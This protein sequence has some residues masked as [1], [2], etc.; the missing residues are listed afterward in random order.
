M[1]LVRYLD[2][3]HAGNRR[4]IVV[5]MG[6]KG[7]ANDSFGNSLQIRVERWHGMIKLIK[8]SEAAAGRPMQFRTAP[9]WYFSDDDLGN[10]RR[11]MYEI[12]VE[13][14]NRLRFLCLGL[15]TKE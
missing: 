11:Y 3:W 2:Y 15:Y 8:R 4:V 1:R 6:A 12:T 10:I 14:G 13:S 9:S 5:E 7:Q